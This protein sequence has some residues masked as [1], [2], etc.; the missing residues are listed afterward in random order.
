MDE[1][2]LSSNAGGAYLMMAR[3]NKLLAAEAERHILLNLANLSQGQGRNKAFGW[4]ELARIRFLAG[5]PE[6][7]SED[8]ARAI[9]AAAS[10]SSSMIRIRLRELLAESEPHA[11]VPCVM[12]LRDRLRTVMAS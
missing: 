6:Q 5:E 11:E 4:I 8:G 10:T 1:A 12:E 2:R 7:A 3:E 9:E